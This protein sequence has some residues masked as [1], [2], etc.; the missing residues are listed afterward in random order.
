MKGVNPQMTIWTILNPVFTAVLVW[1]AMWALKPWAGAKSGEKEKNPAR[2]EDLD[3]IVAELRAVTIV[4]K[5]IEHKLSGEFW[6]RQVRW[7]Q[8]RD[9]YIEIINSAEELSGLYAVLPGVIEKNALTRLNETLS[10]IHSAQQR[11]SRAIT[12]TMLFGTPECALV[13]KPFSD[14]R[15]PLLSDPPTADWAKEECNR[16]ASLVAGIVAEARRDL[17]S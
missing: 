9:A 15:R 7:N 5:E 16:V 14:S 10:Q 12:V 3:A 17:L 6:D 1:L 11:F 8:R 2:K 13:L 4:Q